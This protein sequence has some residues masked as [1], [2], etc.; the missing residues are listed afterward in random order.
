LGKAKEGSEAVAAIGASGL[1]RG[2]RENVDEVLKLLSSNVSREEKMELFRLLGRDLYW[3]T[4]DPTIRTAIART[5]SHTVF[6]LDDKDIVNAATLV[7]TRLGYFPDSMLVL[8]RAAKLGAITQQDFYGE[9]AHM[10]LFAPPTAQITLLQAMENGGNDFSRDVLA[11]MLSNKDAVAALPP[12]VQA[13]SAKVLAKWEPELGQG[14]GTGA[15]INWEHWFEAS[16]HLNAKVMGESESAAAA[17]LLKFDESADP[18]K[19]IFALWNEPLAEIVKAGFDRATLG[20]IDEKL[21]AFGMRYPERAD[22]QDDIQT[23]RRHLSA[24]K[25]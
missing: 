2:T 15:A 4:S 12:Q 1:L 10:F 20:R 18:R 5:L 7:Y 23:A 14:Y 3:D 25:R 9:M 21:A 19:L 17:K 22:I 8:E 11:S 16:V 24:V 6:A 13:A